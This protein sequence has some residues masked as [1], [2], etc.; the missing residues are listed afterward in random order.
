MKLQSLGPLAAAALMLVGPAGAALAQ[1]NAPRMA[2]GCPIADPVK[3]NECAQPKM[4]AFNPP[5]TPDGKLDLSGVWGV[6]DRAP[7]LNTTAREESAFLEKLY[8][9][10]QNERPSRTPW[11]SDSR[12]RP[13]GRPAS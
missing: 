7:G 1:G 11:Q 10:L 8:G 3:F 12:S 5:R 2:A 4:K 13:R 6:V 9:K